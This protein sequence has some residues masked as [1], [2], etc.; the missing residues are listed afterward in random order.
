M[1]K[2]KHLRKIVQKTQWR[3]WRVFDK[4]LGDHCTEEN[5][6]TPLSPKLSRFVCKQHPPA[7]GPHQPLHSCHEDRNNED[8]CSVFHHPPELVASLAAD[9]R[10]TSACCPAQWANESFRRWYSNYMLQEQHILSCSDLKL[11]YLAISVPFIKRINTTDEP[12]SHPILAQ[13][14]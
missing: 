1:D 2:I 10:V 12:L 14:L 8:N 4:L 9:S 6:H 5:P 13:C 7:T 11:F 3:H